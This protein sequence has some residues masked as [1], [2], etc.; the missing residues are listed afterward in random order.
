MP[1]TIG[2]QLR[3]ARETRQLSLDQVVLATRIR[4]RFL[5]ALEND[6]RTEISSPVQGK[7]FLRL[8]AD[9]LGLPVQPLLDLWDGKTS[10]VESEP[11]PIPQSPEASVAQS[12]PETDPLLEETQLA[13][14][15]P[16]EIPLVETPLA[17]NLPSQQIP[18]STVQEPE[19]LPE[20]NRILREIGADLLKRREILGLSVEDIEQH[21]HLRAFY[22]RALEDGR[23]DDLPSPTQGRG[24]LSNYADFLSLNGDTTLLRFADA[25]QARRIELLGPQAEKPVRKPLFKR[26][27]TKDATSAARQLVSPDMLVGLLVIL[28]LVGFA[29]Y[30]ASQISAQNKKLAS[31]IDNP[32]VAEVL[33]LTPSTT[34]L[35]TGTPLAASPSQPAGE[36]GQAA[37]PEIFTA[38][39]P[40]VSDA[41]L[42][43]YVVA[44]G[45]AWMKVIADG[46]IVFQGRVVTGTP[47]PFSAKTS[48]ELV[49]GDALAL[50]VIFNQQ[51]M[52]SLGSSLQVVDLIFNSKG[53]ITPTSAFSP[54]PTFTQQATVT[55]QPTPTAPTATVT[56]LIP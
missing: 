2:Q 56:P 10:V 22:I 37:Q 34:P 48:L 26:P 15:S 19:K 17:E 3:Q 27:N 6:D 38:T 13:R 55:R 5:E 41:P 50:Q 7:G 40:P 28:V 1:E 4:L 49:T 39:P 16:A 42:N 25:L 14:I 12:T 45:N 35:L 31:G 11:N 36:N 9:F 20:S 21:I 18:T 54:T 47:Y 32:S 52:G 29:L 44:K 46:K 8:Y 33:L 23:M 43:I 24:F 51:D 53:V 30:S